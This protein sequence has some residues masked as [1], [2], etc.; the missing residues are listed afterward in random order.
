MVARDP[1]ERFL[2]SLAQTGFRKLLEGV[3]GEDPEI[4]L[5]ENY[6]ADATRCIKHGSEQA[7]VRACM[8]LEHAAIQVVRKANGDLSPEFLK[9]M[10]QALAVGSDISTAVKIALVDALAELGHVYEATGDVPTQFA[11][12]RIVDMVEK[13]STDPTL[14]T[15][16]RKAR[17]RF[18]ILPISRRP[19]PPARRTG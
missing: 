4:E 6:L 2:E 5:T 15:H 12:G 10:T 7:R 17:R 18:T 11:I 16:F 3:E 19:P 13:D 14:L 1:E 8:L 9:A